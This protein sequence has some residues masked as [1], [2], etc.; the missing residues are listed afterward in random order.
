MLKRRKFFFFFFF[1][2]FSVLIIMIFFVLLFLKFII[3]YLIAAEEALKMLPVAEQFTIQQKLS[4]ANFDSLTVDRSAENQTIFTDLHILKHRISSLH[5]MQIIRRKN[6]SS[7]IHNREQL[8]HF[9]EFYSP[10]VHMI[11]N[12]SYLPHNT[13]STTLISSLCYRGRFFDAICLANSSDRRNASSSGANHLDPLVAP[14]SSL[15]IS[16]ESGIGLAIRLLTEYCCYAS[17]RGMNSSVPSIKRTLLNGLAEYQGIFGH[18]TAPLLHWQRLGDNR[19]IENG[20][21]ISSNVWDYLVRMLRLFDGPTNNWALHD[22]AVK[23]Y[24]RLNPGKKLP[25]SISSS[26]CADLIQVEGCLGGDA[27]GLLRILYSEGNL[28]DASEICCRI[29]SSAMSDTSGQKEP[30]IP[31]DF[32]DELVSVMD[33]IGEQ[34]ASASLNQASNAVEIIRTVKR[35]KEMLI[36][37]TSIYMEYRYI[38]EQSKKQIRK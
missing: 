33:S 38:R 7:E 13:D 31:F 32:I 21:S 2:I 10:Q 28:V 11:G 23:E 29:L 18:N 1:A 17:D 20:R 25:I 8:S 22:I 30:N 34:Q 12:N 27:G 24:F 9:K 16:A 35:A 37:Q 36:N 5:A 15:Y 19:F 4:V 26:Y 6:K 3:R 14:I